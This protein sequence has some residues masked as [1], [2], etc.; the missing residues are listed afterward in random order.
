MQA[1]SAG[2]LTFTLTD[3]AQN[4]P[5]R[6]VQRDKVQSTNDEVAFGVL[7]RSGVR[8]DRTGLLYGEA[9]TGA[10]ELNAD[11]VKM[12]GEGT[13]MTVY[14]LS[15]GEPRAFNA[16]PMST[17]RHAVPVGY[18]N[19]PKGELTFAFDAERYGTDGL[20]AVM[21]VDN[22]TGKVTDLLE[23]DYTF[24]NRETGSDSRFVLYGVPA[25]KSSEIA[26]GLTPTFGGDG[27]EVANGIYDLLGRRVHGAILPPGVYIVVENGISRKE[28]IQ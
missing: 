6:K 9:F 16:L 21:L 28:V 10:Y 3:R 20:Q 5:G 7:L 2:T 24:T 14:T 15:Q 23:E 8:A 1:E 13:A 19:A 17:I 25:P 27:R 18:R 26:T 12:F 22:E 11:L 4:S